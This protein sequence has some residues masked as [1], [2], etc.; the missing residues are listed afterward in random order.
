MSYSYYASYI[1]TVP[2]ASYF[3]GGLLIRLG[4]V[5]L[6]YSRFYVTPYDYGLL[7]SLFCMFL[8]LIYFSYSYGVICYFLG[9]S[10][11]AMAYRAHLPCTNAFI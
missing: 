8:L 5:I 2:T 3:L 6:F 7:Y 10:L 9:Y 11:V 4:I 1:M